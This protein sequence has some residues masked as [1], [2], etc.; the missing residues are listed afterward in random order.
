[1]KKRLR[2]RAGTL[3]LRGIGVSPGVAVGPVF[4]V[5][6]E[7]HRFVGRAILVEEIDREI[8][9]FEEAVIETRRQIHAIQHNVQRA[10]GQYDANIFDVHKMVL[11]DSAFVDEVLRRIRQE[12]ENAEAAVRGVSERYADALSVVEDEYL[13]ERVADVKDVARR[14]LRNLCGDQG[15]ALEDL[16][17][18]SIVVAADLAPSETASLRRELAL[19]FVTDQ[20]SYTSHTAIMARALGIPAVVGLGDI[21]AR[22]APGDRILI[23]GTTGEVVLHPDRATMAQHDKTAAAQTTIRTHLGLLRDLPARTTDGHDLTL[24]ANIELVDEIDD[25]Q[26]YGAAG[27]GLLRSEYLYITRGELPTEDEQLAVYRAVAEAVAPH[28][29]IVRT[30]DLGGDKFAHSVRVPD[31]INPFLGFR[32]IRFCLARP[33]IF[34]TQLRAILRASAHGK[35]RIMYPMVSNVDEVIRANALVE[36]CKRELVRERVPFD[37]HTPIGCM[38]EIPS[39]ALTAHVIAEHVQFFSLGTNDLVQYTLAVDR[40]NDR[41]AH[42]YQPT[43]PAV[44]KLIKST[45]DAGHGRGIWVGVCGEMAGDPLLSPLLLGLGIDELSMVPSSVPAVKD[46]IRRVSRAESQR[47]AEHAL[48]AQSAGEVMHFC[49]ELIGRVAPE[50]LELVK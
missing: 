47:L 22:V 50:I 10:I 15:S 21:S 3:V 7:D 45:I 14:V 41:V 34:R 18:K 17:E 36:E 33:E 30:V 48:A 49:R 19:G 37:E 39:A 29:V 32:A 2:R 46:V 40:V 43:H 6:P 27:V 4:R 44:L 20:G 9:R 24:S 26:R 28:P 25:V 11:D 13:R 38:V 5:L 31:E 12:H 1:V 8:S 42:L 16:R 23:D 35:V